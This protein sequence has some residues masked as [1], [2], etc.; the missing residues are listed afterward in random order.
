MTKTKR[1][2]C[3]FL[4]AN[5]KYHD[6]IF[7]RSGEYSSSC[8]LHIKLSF[9]FVVDLVTSQPIECYPMQKFINQFRN[10]W[11]VL[12]IYRI[13]VALML[14]SI[15]R[16]YFFLYNYDLFPQVYTTDFFRMAL[17]GL[18]FDIVAVFYINLL[19]I[20]LCTIPFRF[21]YKQGY[22]KTLKVIYLITNGIA[23]LLNC[24]DIVYFRFTLRRITFSV[25]REFKNETEGFKLLQHFLATYWYMIIFFIAGIYFLYKLYGKN[26]ERPINKW[27]PSL[28]YSAGILLMILFVGLFIA[29]VR[30]GFKHSTRPI[31]LSNSGDYAKNP[32]D[33]NIV[34]N[35]PFT[36]L[37]TI[38]ITELERVN[39]FKSQA[40]L[41]KVYTPVRTPNTTAAFQAKNVVILILESNGKEY[42][43]FYNKKE[44]NGTYK[45]YTPFM[46]SLISK[47]LTFKYSYASGLKSIDAMPSI[48]CSIPY[49]VEPFITTRYAT[50]NKINSIASLL[51]PKGYF[52]AYFHG[53][54]NGSMGFQAFANLVGYDAYFGKNE[55]NNDADFDN[56]WGIWDEEFFQFYARKMNG[57]KQPFLTT[58]F[59]VSSHDPFKVPQ[60][61]E[62]KFPKGTLPIHQCIGYTDMALRKFFAT[63]SK[64]SWYKNT[65]FVMVADHTNQKYLESYKS[66]LNHF[67]IPIVFF[68][69]SKN[70]AEYNQTDVVE[71]SDIMPSILG[72]LNYD[73]PYVAFGFDIFHRQKEKYF[74]VNYKS[75]FYQF[76]KDDYLLRFDGNKTTAIYNFKKDIMLS[77]NLIANSKQKT[78]SLTTELK[79]FVQQYNI[80]MLDNR[81]T[82]SE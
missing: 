70:L 10:N 51:K 48:L 21:R 30:G 42:Y 11:N 3:Y 18:R 67:A 29:G 59:S 31:T 40:P 27:R 46:D 37:K 73:K 65:L 2:A 58:L 39:Y 25:F 5:H 23:L 17:G 9:T 54:P 13:V 28:Y 49:M 7:M 20:L 43:G 56:I 76:L 74:A 64:M 36:I 68:D 50:N 15:C 52:S 4:T 22:Q 62:G 44:E 61:Y 63:A 33:V 8:S 24:I 72:Y 6:I 34:L 53:A 82:I 45:G 1:K 75:G 38:E 35:T 80:R 55:Y 81:L 12:F 69:P 14:F 19:F 16:L 57:F 79:A 32:L 60:R 66:D 41:D 78:D 71:Q 26:I 47:S 77:N